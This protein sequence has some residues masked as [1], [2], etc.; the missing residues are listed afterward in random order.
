[1]T[2]MHG[3]TTALFCCYHVNNRTSSFTVH[4]IVQSIKEDN[5]RGG[6]NNTRSILLML[7]ALSVLQR[8]KSVYINSL[9]AVF[10]FSSCL[11]VTKVHLNSR[12]VRKK[13]I[14]YNGNMRKLQ[15]CI[16]YNLYNK[17]ERE[18]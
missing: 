8:Y 3:K 4:L 15:K 16:K 17:E 5:S 13:S 14:R 9:A 6:Q 10:F 18:A 7:W 1:M 2:V 11:K 12:Q